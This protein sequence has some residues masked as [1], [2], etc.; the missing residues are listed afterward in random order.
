MNYWIAEAKVVSSG[1]PSISTVFP[2]LTG[3]P[4]QTKYKTSIQYGI[5]IH[6]RWLQQF[7]YKPEEDEK[8][9]DEEG[10]A[11]AVM[12]PWLRGG[13]PHAH[14]RRP[15]NR[16]KTERERERERERGGTNGVSG[17]GLLGSDCSRWCVC[18]AMC[19]LPRRSRQ[20]LFGCMFFRLFAAGGPWTP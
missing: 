19:H 14:S 2:D 6:Q 1:A 12:L 7:A 9:E 18:S 20:H 5:I 4:M 13:R 16:R 8:N 17:S 11:E 15:P 10:A 3:E